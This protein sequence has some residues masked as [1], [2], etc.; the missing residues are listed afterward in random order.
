MSIFLRH[1]SYEKGEE[2]S[3][4]GRACR[5]KVGTFFILFLNNIEL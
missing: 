5:T 2:G 4:D 1:L 3:I